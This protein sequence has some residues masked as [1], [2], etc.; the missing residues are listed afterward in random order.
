MFKSDERAFQSAKG[1]GESGSNHILSS[2]ANLYYPSK[3]SLGYGNSAQ[4]LLLWLIN[5]IHT[6]MLKF[7]GKLE[8]KQHEETRALREE[9]G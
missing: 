9:I 3:H 1:L 6:E 2:I 4:L 5:R 8:A 7:T